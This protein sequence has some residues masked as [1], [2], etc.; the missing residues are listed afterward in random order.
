MPHSIILKIR[1][2]LSAKVALIVTI[3]VVLIVSFGSYR[4]YVSERDMLFHN[5]E[6]QLY[7]IAEGLRMTAETYLINR[8]YSEL[9]NLVLRTAKEPDIELA[10]L[11]D[12]RGNAL[13]GNKKEWIG[14]NMTDMRPRE[15]TDND[16]AAL[17]KALG[18]EYSIYYDPLDNQYCLA[19]P[20]TIG[21]EDVGVLHLSMDVGKLRSDVH[22]SAV[23]NVLISLLLSV[24]IGA[25]LFF[26]FQRLLTYRIKAV[27]TTA[28][29]LASGDMS[30]RAEAGGSDEIAYLATSFNLMAE[31]ITNWR[32]NLE[33][34]A[35][36]R[37][38]ELMVLF[39]VVNTISQSLELNK[40]LPKVLESVIG[41]MGMLKGVIV[42][43][44][45]DGKS[46][47][48]GA[49]RG[50]S[51]ESLR[52]ITEVGQGCIGDVILRNK[53]MRISAGEEDGPAAVP[54][55]EQDNILSALVVPISA[56][57]VVLGALALYC[58]ARDKFT[59][60]DEALLATIGNQ[61]SVA[62]LNARLYEKTLEL[63]QVDGLT[64][65]ANRRFLMEQLKQELDRAERYHTSLSV[66]M[67]DLD[68]FKSFNDSYGHLKGDE[69]LRT[70]C[71]MVK[72]AVRSTDIAGRY[73]GEEFCIVLPSTSIKG[74]LVIAERI[75][76]SAEE[77]KIPLDGDQPPV[78]RTVSIGVSEFTAGETVEKLL[79][80]ADAALYRAKEGGRNRVE[81]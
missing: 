49:Q 19:M 39:D 31:E 69:L 10:M 51:E 23:E 46:L 26:L 32:S 4:K 72:S 59:D 44:G 61:V 78:G 77:L 22:A 38:S 43:V 5:T 6:M 11:F 25:S 40:V 74:A 27:S 17:R 54:G 35:T 52:R 42:L 34:M 14:K 28:A 68:K 76:K 67:M 56:R 29:Q 75:R 41:S 21:G 62:V 66:I 7:R 15:L 3:P 55:L 71:G 45:K 50:L 33:E 58:E 2:S 24:L 65:V 79:S 80:G 16:I 13:A 81:S 12:H 47:L 48:I 20:V 1:S 64:G 57:D 53:P 60:N 37:M 18:G 9:Q 70:F 73:G 8:E 36:N 30:V 63:A